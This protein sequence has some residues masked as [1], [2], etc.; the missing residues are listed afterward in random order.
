MVKILDLVKPGVLYGDDVTKVFEHAK[1]KKFAIPAVN[2]IGTNTI[3]AALEV[4]RDINSPIIIQLSNGGAAFYAGKAIDNSEQRASIL[5]A[6]SAAEHVHR[7]A[8]EYGVAVIMHSDHC[9]KKLLPWLDGMIKEDQKFFKKNKKPLFSSHMIDLS[10][11]PL[12]DN[13][14]IAKKYLKKLDA[15]NMTLELEVGVTGGEEDGV[16]N[17]GLENS[18]LYTQ[19]EDIAYTYEELNK[20]SKRFTVAATFGNVHGV[21]KPGNVKLEPII[22]NNCQKYI[23]KKFNT[24]NKKPVNF[25]FHGGSGSE[26]EKIKEAISY[27][28]VKMNIDTDTQFAFMEGIRDYMNTNKLYLK[29]KV[30]NPEGKDKPNKKHFDPRVWLRSGEE[31]FKTRLTQAYLDLN[32]KNRN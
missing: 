3:N 15:M 4:A 26:P 23:A 8:K 16:N 14:K 28:V 10:L 17:T 1:E 21:Y 9:A 7:M 22:L 11:E 6:I 29:R 20:V 5:G 2:C 32:C 30:G 12:K 19:P 18:R 13:V 25:V 31:T 24:K 27:G